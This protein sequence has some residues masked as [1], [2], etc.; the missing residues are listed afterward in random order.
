MPSGLI[1][2]CFSFSFWSGVLICHFILLDGVD[3][4][5]R[6]VIVSVHRFHLPA[7]GQV[8]QELCILSPLQSL[9]TVPVCAWATPWYCSGPVGSPTERESNRARVQGCCC[10]L[11]QSHQDTLPASGL[12]QYYG[13]SQQPGI[14]FPRSADHLCLLLGCTSHCTWWPGPPY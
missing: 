13:S 14:H 2:G 9:S 8:P 6:I 12:Q 3:L 1:S 11:P 10:L 4:C 7:L 5:F